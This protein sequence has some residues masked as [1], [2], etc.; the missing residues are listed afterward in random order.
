MNQNQ[1]PFRRI[2]TGHDE[3]GNAVI[4]SDAP[5]VHT[6][7][8]GGPGGPTFFE[9]W[10]TIETPAPIHHQPDLPDESNLV[11][12]P[13]KNGTRIR[14]IEFP[15]EGEEIRKLTGADAAA[16]FKSMGDEKA[17]TNTGEAPHPLMHRTETV[18]YGIV[19]EGEITL[20]LDRGETIIY[21]GDVVIQSGTN[22]AWANRSN[23][24]CRMAF[25]LI[26]G[27]YTN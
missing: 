19:L 26:N 15:P 5:P 16:K 3:N 6:Q 7:L 4:V 20:V 27:E 1:K 9:I 13:P 17:S 25:V 23:K 24:I 12:P 8:V 2:V 11:L 22:H 18:D 10:H 21:P 14:I